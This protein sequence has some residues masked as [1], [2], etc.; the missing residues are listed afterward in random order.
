MFSF[1]N[2][3]HNGTM[4]EFWSTHTNHRTDEYG[5]SAKNRARLMIEVMDAMKQT[6]GR[7]FP[8]EMLISVDGLGV[9]RGDTF[10]LAKLLELDLNTVDAIAVAGGP[11][12]FTGLRLV[13]P[14][15]RALDWH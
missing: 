1:H 4:A 11:G 12:S 13:R 7:D 6:F 9:N 14:L 8:I 3:Y 2:A 10:E 15:P 5:G